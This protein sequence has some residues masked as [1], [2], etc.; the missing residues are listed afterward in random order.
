M[1]RTIGLEQ[2]CSDR[3]SGA[4]SWSTTGDLIWESG[5]MRMM[6]HTVVRLNGGTRATAS[7]TYI[8]E[9]LVGAVG[10][11]ELDALK[12]SVRGGEMKRCIVVAIT[13]VHVGVPIKEDLDALMV[14]F[15]RRKMKRCIIVVTPSVGIGVPIKEELDALM[16]AIRRCDMKSGIVVTVGVDIGMLIKKGLDICQRALPGCDN[17]S[18]I[19]LLLL[20]LRCHCVSRVEQPGSYAVCVC[21]FAVVGV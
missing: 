13:I 10:K 2:S 19:E 1:A 15:R 8:D 7:E 17:K 5:G 12:A 21:V 20:A 11:K 6:G 3:I 4:L 14:A 9:R 16:V 18:M